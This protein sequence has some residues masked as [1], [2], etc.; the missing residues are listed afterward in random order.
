MIPAQI[1][2]FAASM[3]MSILRF[4]LAKD[5]PEEQE[6]ALMEAAEKIALEQ[7]RRKFH[8]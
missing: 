2:E 7:K 8:P 5:D 4:V 6:S 1:A 3:F